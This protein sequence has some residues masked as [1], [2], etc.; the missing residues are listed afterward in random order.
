MRVTTIY[1]GSA[2]ATAKYYTQYLTQAVGEE[3]GCWLGAQAAEFG[4]S[5][6][7]STEALESLLSGC[8]PTT[9]ASL[10]RP[11]TDR[12]LTNG[13]LVKAVK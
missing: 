13:K 1:A 4:L 3:P 11:L 6:Q 2:A 9:G 5:G 8:D 7:V 10:G 12:F